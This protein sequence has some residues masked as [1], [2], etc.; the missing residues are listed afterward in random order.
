MIGKVKVTVNIME[1]KSEI[2]MKN[3]LKSIFIIKQY[4]TFLMTV[5]ILI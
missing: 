1:G 3:K 5:V 4:F 2:D